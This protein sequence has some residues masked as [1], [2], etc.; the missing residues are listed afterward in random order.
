[1]LDVELLKGVVVLKKC[2]LEK[3]CTNNVWSADGCPILTFWFIWQVYFRK[4]HLV[5][6]GPERT[7]G[8]R[9]SRPRAAGQLITPLSLWHIL[10][11]L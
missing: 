8:I 11:F 7:L 3:I 9:P 2:Q 6:E 4:R 5:P 1:M 10:L